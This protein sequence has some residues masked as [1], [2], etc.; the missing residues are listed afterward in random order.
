MDFWIFVDRNIVILDT[1]RVEVVEDHLD[2]VNVN[3]IPKKVV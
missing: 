3:Y 2:V 1:L